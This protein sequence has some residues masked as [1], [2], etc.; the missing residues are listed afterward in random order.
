MSKNEIK[1]NL[2]PFKNLTEAEKVKM[3]VKYDIIVQKI[4]QYENREVDK[5]YTAYNNLND[6]EIKCLVGTNYWT[7]M[8]GNNFIDVPTYDLHFWFY[9]DHKCFDVA[10]EWQR[11]S[12]PDFVESNRRKA[13][14]EQ[15]LLDASNKI[16]PVPEL[17]KEPVRE[18]KTEV[19]KEVEIVEQPKI[20][21]MPI[22]EN[23]D[24]LKEK[25]EHPVYPKR[26][27][28]VKVNSEKEVVVDDKSVKGKKGKKEK[29]KQEDTQ[30][31]LF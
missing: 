17:I 31:S 14:A 20:E 8:W 26:E 21:E 6:Y 4:K 11:V 23:N 28:I 27:N 15:Q 3:R 9:F 7:V 2:P 1:R 18:P 30:G 16:K 25:H 5:S 22:E 13:E 10:P 29:T 24:F 12:K 19:I